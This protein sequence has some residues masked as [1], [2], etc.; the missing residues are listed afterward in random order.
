[1]QLSIMDHRYSLNRSRSLQND[2]NLHRYLSLSEAIIIPVFCVCLIAAIG[3]AT[4][5]HH[6]LVMQFEVDKDTEYIDLNIAA[7][8]FSQPRQSYKSFVNLI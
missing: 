5:L 3:R 4:G 7:L 1:M 2:S 8:M 6:V